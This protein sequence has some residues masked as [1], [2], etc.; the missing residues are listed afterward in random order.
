MGIEK[1]LRIKFLR[2]QVSK[3]W[4]VEIVSVLWFNGIDSLTCNLI[5]VII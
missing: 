1:S 3:H 4:F 2:S 5:A